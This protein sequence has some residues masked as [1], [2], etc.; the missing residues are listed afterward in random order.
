MHNGIKKMIY[1]G[2]G[3]APSQYLFD[4][5]GVGVG[6]FSFRVLSQDSPTTN[7]ILSRSIDSEILNLG[8]GSNDSI[9]L[10]LAAEFAEDGN[11]MCDE[12]INQGSLVGVNFLQTAAGKKPFLYKAGVLQTDGGK[13]C[14][15]FD[16]GQCL[17]AGD[18]FGT[19]SQTENGLYSYMSTSLG[20]MLADS[21]VLHG[22]ISAYG[23]FGQRGV[24]RTAND[25]LLS[26]SGYYGTAKKNTR[27]LYSNLSSIT[28]ASYTN[29]YFY[30]NNIL[31]ASWT[32]RCAING[33]RY[34]IGAGDIGGNEFWYLNGKFQELIIYK[35]LTAN[36]PSLSDLNTDLITYY[37]I[38]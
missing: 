12:W 31:D 14:L 1:F 6:G 2:R 11:V 16:G 10:A 21:N 25:Y 29:D 28:V 4:I 18:N 3:V 36:V 15:K 20:S 5:Y 27:A 32:G 17:S 13:P 37:G 19:Y 26:E 24:V 9:D 23:V 8:Y 38:S 35:D 33:Y 30:V 7:I 34:L 22:K